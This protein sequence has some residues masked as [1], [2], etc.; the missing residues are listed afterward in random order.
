MR[1]RHFLT[2]KLEQNNVLLIGAGIWYQAN[3]FPDLHDTRTY[4][5]LAPEKNGADLRRQFLVQHTQADDPH[6][7]KL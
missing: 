7:T 6:F 2:W 1:A 4:P 5:K 3:P